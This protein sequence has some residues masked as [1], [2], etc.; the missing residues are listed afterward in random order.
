G[1]DVLFYSYEHLN[2]I[3]NLYSLDNEIIDNTIECL[4]FDDILATGG[5][6]KAVIEHFNGMKI[7]N[8][9]LKINTALFYVGIR[10]LKG[11]ENL[12]RINVR[13]IHTV[14]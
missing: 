11:K 1:E 4:F 3:L 7:G 2:N 14:E 13:C 12:G 6:A 9:T 10:H 5:T 8:I